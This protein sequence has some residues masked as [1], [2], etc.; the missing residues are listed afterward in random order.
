MIVRIDLV[1]NNYKKTRTTEAELGF[2]DT[3]FNRLADCSFAGI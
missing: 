1:A 3:Y 2:T